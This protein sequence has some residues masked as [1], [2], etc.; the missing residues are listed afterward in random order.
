MKGVI[1]SINPQARIVDITHEIPPQDVVAAAFTLL[2][3][4]QS[5]PP[6]TIHVGVVDPGVGSSRR[7]ILATAAAQYFVGPDNGIFSYVLEREQEVQIFHL[8]REK[9]FR[10]PVSA[11]FH[12][13]DVFAPVAATLSNGVLPAKLGRKIA[14][15]VSLPTGVP[16]KSGKSAL[17]GCIL[18]I[19]HF[20]NCITNIT[21]ENVP[22]DWLSNGIRLKVA[23]KVIKTLR[24]CFAEGNDKPE[25]LFAI[26]GS[27]G[28]LEIAAA[29][30]SAAEMLRAK[31][32]EVVLLS[33][34]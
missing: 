27:A 18:H 4:Y 8:N 9:Y 5:F 31:R 13:R 1:L 12:G 21:R 32:G 2:A 17:R 6:G 26:W 33:T 3:A 11:T 7:P 34:P 15:P 14:D 16:V 30:R 22:V 29:N 19:D 10:H 20:G 23:G 28:F 24:R 25:E